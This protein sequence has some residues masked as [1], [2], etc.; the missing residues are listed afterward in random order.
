RNLDHTADLGIEVWAD[1]RESLLAH[2]S[3][4][5]TGQMV[6]ISTVKPVR[7]V[8]W[9]VD[10]D[11]P[12]DLLVG[13]LQE[14]LFRLDTEGMVFSEFRISLRGLNTIKCLAYG[15]PLNRER[16]GFKTEIKAVTYHH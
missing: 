1:S 4:A 9:T 16:H 7:E 6:D 8:E 11:S 5:L 2:A 15:E 12:E 14:I 3:E 13:Q 10:G